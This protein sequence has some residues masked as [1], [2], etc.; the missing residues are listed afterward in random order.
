MTKLTRLRRRL[1]M[2]RQAGVGAEVEPEGVAGKE[3]QTRPGHGEQH[4]CPQGEEQV[5]VEAA[6]RGIIRPQ[7][8][9][10]S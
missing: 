3:R 1:W 5:A 8:A 7:R 10:Q 2:T 4:R 6:W 9:A